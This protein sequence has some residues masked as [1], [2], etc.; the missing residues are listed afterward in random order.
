MREILSPQGPPQKFTLIVLVAV[1]IIKEALFRRVLRTG[2]TLDSSALRADAWHHRSDALTSAAAFIGIAIALVG[3]KGFEA[4]DDW[5]ALV[6]C[7]DY[8]V[9][10]QLL[11]GTLDEMMDAAVA[12][13]SFAKCAKL[14]ASVEGV[15]AIE[16]PHPQTGFAPGARHSRGRGRRQAC[17][18]AAIATKWAKLRSSQRRINDVTVHI[19]PDRSEEREA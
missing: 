7:R 15:R 2:T 8:C 18:G 17:G 13:G 3:G 5:A 12:G 16:V 1:V 6:A 11:R 14:A 19:R 9:E 4:A 10:W